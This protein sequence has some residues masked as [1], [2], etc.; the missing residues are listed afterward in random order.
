MPKILRGYALDAIDFSSGPVS[1]AA[2]PTDATTA[3][4]TVARQFMQLVLDAPRTPFAAPGLGEAWRLFAPQVSGGGLAVNGGLV[5]LPAFGRKM[6]SDAD[7]RRKSGSAREVE[8][9]ARN[10]C[11]E[12]E[13][14]SR[15]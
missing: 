13:H 12:R 8:T 2:S 1:Q 5:H 15:A 11:T 3:R 4:L 6:V 10:A 7:S 14:A 9:V